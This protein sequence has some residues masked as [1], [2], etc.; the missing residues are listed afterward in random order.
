MWLYL[1]IQYLNTD[2]LFILEYMNYYFNFS[3]N[4]VL[5][6]TNAFNFTLNDVSWLKQNINKFTDLL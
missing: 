6:V 3:Y 4:G 2:N 1:A 5:E